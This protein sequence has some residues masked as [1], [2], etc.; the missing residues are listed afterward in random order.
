SI[1]WYCPLLLWLCYC[2]R[3]LRRCCRRGGRLRSIWRERCGR[4]ELND[5]CTAAFLFPE[6]FYVIFFARFE[7]HCS[8]VAEV[9]G[10]FTDCGADAGVG[11][12]CNN[13]DLFHRRRGIA[14]AVAV[15]RAGPCDGALRCAGRHEA[16]G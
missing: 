8:S 9:T 6:R 13:R 15:S 16:G 12:R 3:W 5:I 10:V 1:L 11:N 14:A 4:S 2:W 7:N